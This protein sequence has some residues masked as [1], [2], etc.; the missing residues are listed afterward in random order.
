MSDS[1]HPSQPSGPAPG[2]EPDASASPQP[3]TGAPT[4]AE[5][6]MLLLFQPQS[7]LHSGTGSIAGEGTLFYVLA[8]AVLTD[9][10]LGG[11]V[12]TDE[13]SRAARVEAVADDPPTDAL[14]RKGW[15]YIAQRPRGVQ[16][17]L[18]AIG[19]TL[20]APVLERLVERGDIE[21]GQ[22]K[23][24]GLFT[25]DVL[26]GDGGER[27]AALMAEVRGVLVDGAEPSPRIAALGALLAASGTLPQF[28]SEIPWTTPVI[29]RAERLKRGEWGAGAAAQAVARTT[30][31][32]VV[33]NV[34]VAAAVLPRT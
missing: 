18:A 28:D 29:E 7:G 3:T 17:V 11:H 19:P 5:D 32:I 4:L 21:R 22:R 20:R 34:I 6:L 13:S 24:L 26:E 9:L 16:T 15:E 23:S 12:T 30:T 2:A 1:V 25:T 27:R 14:L 10:A 33:N 8:G 31:A